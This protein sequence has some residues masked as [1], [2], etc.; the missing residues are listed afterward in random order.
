MSTCSARHSHWLEIQ[1]WATA[2]TF[3]HEPMLLKTLE[4]LFAAHG[5]GFEYPGFYDS[6]AFLAVERSDAAFLEKYAE[7]VDHQHYSQEYV[8]R[9][10]RVVPLLSR[11]VYEHLIREGRLGACI[12]VSSMVSRMLDMEG[13]WSYTAGGGA[14][15]SF[16]KKS[17]LSPSYFGVIGGESSVAAHVWIRVPPFVVLDITLPAQPWDAR[18][19]PYLTDFVISERSRA[20]EPTV[21]QLIDMDEIERFRFTYGRQPT[22]K[23]VAQLIPHVFP[24]MER[25]PSFSVEAGSLEIAYVPTK[26]GAS[27]E[28]LREMQVPK[29]CGYSPWELYQR[30]KEIVTNESD[31]LTN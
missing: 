24:F 6:P 4:A 30:F 18:R 1:I 21:H 5:I 12:D 8:K 25:F 23:D 11:F 14:S 22:M 2:L 27:V 13:I 19:R 29:L 3:Y 7:Y 17:G 15:I 28:P 9:V 20:S 31:S 16:P 26:I 10:Q